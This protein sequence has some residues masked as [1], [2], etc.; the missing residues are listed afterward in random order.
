MAR[1]S[2]SQGDW[3]DYS[4]CSQLIEWDTGERSVRLAYYRRRAGEDHWEFA[5]QM[6]VCSDPA[7]IKELLERTLAKT[8]WFTAPSGIGQK[9]TAVLTEDP[10]EPAPR[11]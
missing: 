8:E 9:P 11:G 4:F 7:T 2:T 5:S 10:T 1:A 3:G 6:T